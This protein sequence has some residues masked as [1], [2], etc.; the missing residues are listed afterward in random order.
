M[1]N[2]VLKIFGITAILGLVGFLSYKY[3]KS[4]QQPSE[5]DTDTSS[6]PKVSGSIGKSNYS[7]SIGTGKYSGSI[8]TGK[9]DYLDKKRSKSCINDV[10]CN[11][12]SNHLSVFSSQSKYGYGIFM[13]DILNNLYFFT[14]KNG[15]W[16]YQLVP[17][18][19]EIE[20]SLIDTFIIKDHL[21]YAKKGCN[22][23]VYSNG[24]LVFNC[25][26]EKVKRSSGS[27]S[28]GG[29]FGGGRWEC[30]WLSGYQYEECLRKV[31]SKLGTNLASYK[32]AIGTSQ[33]NNWW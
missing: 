9:Y 31:A 32:S 5:E 28:G 23:I 14:V 15:V 16:V 27:S 25:K 20:P 22:G 1:N 11:S 13:Y 24:N 7:G 17:S 33:Y 26:K 19:Y 29:G 18:Y 21:K 2:K 12:F 8:G 30:L 3:I 4:I 10:L 6:T